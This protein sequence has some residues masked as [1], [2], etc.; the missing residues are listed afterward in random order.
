[1]NASDRKSR[2]KPTSFGE[3]NASGEFSGEPNSKQASLKLLSEKRMEKNSLSS[4]I[5]KSSLPVLGCVAE[6]A[7]FVVIM[8]NCNNRRCGESYGS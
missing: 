3:V 2:K 4:A 7:Y 8:M 1:M 6:L 5:M